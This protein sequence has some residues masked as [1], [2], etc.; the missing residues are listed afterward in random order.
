M[1]VTIHYKGKLNATELIGPFLEEIQDIAQSLEWH[2]TVINRKNDDTT[3]V[4]GLFIQ[5]HPK[6]EFLTF[7]VDDKGHLRN[8]VMLQHFED[9]DEVTWSN[10]IKTQFAPVEIHI[11]IIKL[12]R[13]LK[14][15]YM[16]SLEVYDEGL[17]WE[18][19]DVQKVTERIN[20]L[21]KA[22][23]QLEG[24]LNSIPREAGDN[25]ESIADKIEKIIRARMNKKR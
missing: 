6:S 19:N 17:F 9:N 15:K 4:Q 5:P 12:L 14:G 21:N 10:S 3:P 13:Y 20:V 8:A 2:Y 16:D 18:T 1:G 7:A 23:D 24:I 25:A 22:M 11:A